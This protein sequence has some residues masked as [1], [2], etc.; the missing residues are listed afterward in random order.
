MSFIAIHYY[1]DEKGEWF[2]KHAVRSILG[3]SHR[4]TL[5]SYLKEVL[6]GLPN[7]LSVPTIQVLCQM[8]TWL[9]VGYGNRKYSKQAFMVRYRT[10]TLEREFRRLC[11]PIELKLQHLETKIQSAR[12]T[13]GTLQTS[14]Q[15]S[16]A[17]TVH[18]TDVA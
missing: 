12:Q 7:Y 4:H 10:N 1:Q 11:V 2:S 15:V 13:Y 8:Q 14:H 9:Q 17:I 3:I 5:N 16:T 18:S 6:G